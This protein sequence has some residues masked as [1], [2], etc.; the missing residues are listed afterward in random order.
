VCVCVLAGQVP[1]EASKSV[2]SGLSA[3]EP[4]T[5]QRLAV[6][7]KL[8]G[9]HRSY[10]GLSVFCDVDKRILQRNY[11]D[12]GDRFCNLAVPIGRKTRAGD[13]CTAPPRSPHIHSVYLV[14]IV[15]HIVNML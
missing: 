8:W 1:L 4:S 13:W 9:L 6:A 11:K 2:K 14:Q 12:A 5:P 10:I 3:V 7:N 15:F